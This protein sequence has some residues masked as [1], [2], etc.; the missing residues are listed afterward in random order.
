MKIAICEDELIFSSGIKSEAGSFFA[1]KGISVDIDVFT[2][3]RGLLREYEKGSAYS[4]VFMDI[5]LENSD[6]MKTAS[7]L[8]KYDK[9]ALLV[10]I[11]SVESR[12]VDG[13]DV[14]AFGY[15]VKNTLEERLPLLL[16]RLWNELDK[17][18]L[19]VIKDSGVICLLADDIMGIESSGRGAV[20]HTLDGEFKT[21]ENIGRL[22]GKLSPEEFIEC[23]KSVF[24]NVAQIKSI[25]INFLT[26]VSGKTFPVSRRCRKYVMAALMKKAGEM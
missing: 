22:S 7:E 13:Y 6:G 3:G 18:R 20:I 14:N 1:E 4:I 12:A 21:A 15:I 11:T 24:V 23:H 10:F 2:D 9:K 8:R 5:N 19:L 25:D 16:E 17:E 26:T